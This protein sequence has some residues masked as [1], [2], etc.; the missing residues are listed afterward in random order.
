MEYF[1]SLE[2]QLSENVNRKKTPIE[3]VRNIILV[4]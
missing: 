2:D 4:K 3:M 1:N